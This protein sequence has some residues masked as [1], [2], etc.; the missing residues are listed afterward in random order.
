MSLPGPRAEAWEARGQ[1]FNFKLLNTTLNILT[2][3]LSLTSSVP[4]SPQP[5]PD[6]AI[7]PWSVRSEYNL[8]VSSNRRLSL[9]QCS[10]SLTLM[11]QLSA[12]TM[13][14]KAFRQSH[15]DIGMTMLAIAAQRGLLISR[16]SQLIEQAETAFKIRT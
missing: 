8:H 14:G 16:I 1:V 7:D 13:F 3:G 12:G 2:S 11:K 10:C 6:S 9:P 15:V 4:A 5:S